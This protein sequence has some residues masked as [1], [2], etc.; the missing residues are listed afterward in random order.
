VDG[1]PEDRPLSTETGAEAGMESSWGAGL[2]LSM[3][4]PT[5]DFSQH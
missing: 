3:G 5:N 4:D 1:R 2:A